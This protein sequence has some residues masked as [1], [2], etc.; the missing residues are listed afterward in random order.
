MMETY[1]KRI[2]VKIEN[3]KTFNF[4]LTKHMYIVIDMYSPLCTSPWQNSVIYKYG[5]HFLF[6]PHIS[7]TS[8]W[9]WW[10][11]PKDVHHCRMLSSTTTS[12]PP[13]SHITSVVIA[14]AFCTPWFRAGEVYH[15]A[16]SRGGGVWEILRCTTENK[17][18]SSGMMRR[19]L[20]MWGH[21][22]QSAYHPGCGCRRIIWSI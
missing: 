6:L 22:D 14:I 11:S 19:W 10:G 20:T 17:S 3:W 13:I 4:L 12:L 21:Q 9:A 18:Y 7:P 2:S 15:R 16:D 8:C 5:E 1:T